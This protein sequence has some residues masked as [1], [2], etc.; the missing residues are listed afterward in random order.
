[1]ESQATEQPQ[2][3]IVPPTPPT[4]QVKNS[5]VLIMSVLLIVA[6]GIAA[7]FYFQIQKL[8]K[9]ISKNQVQISPTPTATSNPTEGWKTESSSRIS[10]K[11]PPNLFLEERQKNYFVLLSDSKNPS[12]VFVSIDARLS[13]TYA[14]YD[15]AVASTKSGL[16]DIQTQE[17]ENGVK[18]SGKLGPGFAQGQQVTV[19]LLKYLEG[20]VE[21]ETT[22]TDSSKLKAFDTILST[23]KLIEATPSANS[24]S[25]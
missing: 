24:T 7:L 19:A 10:F 20:V 5:L 16:T 15:K 11:Y 21:A 6:V 1:M 18:I 13:G 25:N 12:S 23:F 3:P 8:S 9:E 14:N 17:I 2:A 22:A 4:P